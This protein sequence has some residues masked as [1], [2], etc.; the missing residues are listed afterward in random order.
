MIEYHLLFLSLK[1]TALNHQVDSSSLRNLC[2]FAGYEVLVGRNNRQN[3]VLTNRV[4]SDYD[5]WFHARN[6]PGSHVHFFLFHVIF[7][8]NFSSFLRNDRYDQMITAVIRMTGSL[9]CNSILKC[10]CT[11]FCY[12]IMKGGFQFLKRKIG[13]IPAFSL[14]LHWQTVLRVPPGQNATDE[15]LQFS[16]DLAAYFSKVRQF[17]LRVCTKFSLSNSGVPFHHWSGNYCSTLA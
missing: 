13:M 11:S 14:S 16:A 4:A 10:W 8:S 7:Y 17:S 2:L 5:L 3:D 15:D 12:I 9:L 1:K 6:I